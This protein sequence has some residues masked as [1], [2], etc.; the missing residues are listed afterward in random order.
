MNI[1]VWKMFEDPNKNMLLFYHSDDTA[2]NIKGAINAIKRARCSTICIDVFDDVDGEYHCLESE[3]GDYTKN[4]MIEFILEHA[5]KED[6]ID[7]IL[8][9]LYPYK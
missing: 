9:L 5:A 7:Y 1:T 2:K 8:P 4:E 6:I 3:N